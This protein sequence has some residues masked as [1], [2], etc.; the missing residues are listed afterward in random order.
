MLQI[1]FEGPPGHGKND[2]GPRGR[3]L[4]QVSGA[5]SGYIETAVPTP[6]SIDTL[7]LWGHGDAAKLCGMDAKDISEVVKKWKAVNPGLKTVE[8]ITCNARHASGGGKAF[9]DQLKNKLHGFRS[10][11]R[12]VQ[13]KGLP[14][15]V[16]GKSNAWSILLAEP[17]HKSWVYITAPGAND[18][19]LMQAKSLIDFEPT[20]NGQGLQSYRGDI[21]IKADG[22]VR[23][24]P[25]NRQ[26]TMNYGYL[27]TL[28]SHLV[29]V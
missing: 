18:S 22:S 21:A 29:K 26:W 3:A 25:M 2:H 11:T 1:L 7:T 12:D 28:R 24:A 19:L 27:N 14:V 5:G 6:K 20:P 13:I 4:A 8:I 16:G 15:A 10:S 23:T 17:T 9:V